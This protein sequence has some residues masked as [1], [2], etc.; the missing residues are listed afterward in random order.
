[1]N[2]RLLKN[3]VFSYDIKKLLNDVLR[4]VLKGVE[5]YYEERNS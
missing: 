5:K 2:Q 3:G 1:M 4:G